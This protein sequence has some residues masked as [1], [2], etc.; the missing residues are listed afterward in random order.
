MVKKI[1]PALGRRIARHIAEPNA[2]DAWPEGK[3]SRVF[4]MKQPAN[5]AGKGMKSERI[6][7]LHRSMPAHDPFEHGIKRSAAD[8]A[9]DQGKRRMQAA[10][11]KERQQRRHAKRGWEVP[12]KLQH[13]EHMTSGG[14][15]LVD[16]HGVVNPLRH[17]P[18]QR[19]GARE[20]RHPRSKQKPS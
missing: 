6:D 12:G 14:F 1:H 11:M 10:P 9:Q 18:I 8:T 15:F 5:A 17:P 2:S 4:R 3:E 7:P 20:R 13:E 19:K 16:R